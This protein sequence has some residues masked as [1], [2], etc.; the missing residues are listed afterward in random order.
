MNWKHAEEYVEKKR[1][2]KVATGIRC[3]QCWLDK[4]ELC[5]CARLPRIAF[6]RCF[7]F[8]V[9]QDFKEYLNPGDDAKLLL[10]TSPEQTTLI[11]Y[12]FEDQK[13]VD[14]L[15]HRPQ[16]TTS[17]GT[18]TATSSSSGSSSSSSSNVS[19]NGPQRSDVCILFPSDTSLSAAEFFAHCATCGRD[20]PSRL[21]AADAVDGAGGSE[22]GVLTIIVVDA[23][24]RHAR[25]MTKHLSELLP[26]VARV[27]LTPEQFSVY[28]R[29]QTQPDRIC[30]LEATA[31]FLQ[32]C[33]EQE[34]PCQQLI[35]CVKLNNSMLKRKPQS[36]T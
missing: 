34:A 15:A 24:W 29:K 22:G 36:V 12:P 2:A 17:T 4:A 11:L 16:P 3:G 9:Y 30:T 35:D 33:G 28:A 27:Q 25:K 26:D 1:A 8:V 32:H 20:W 10:C 23:V 14:L 21:N 31:L 13:L 19:S 5:I 18:A 7:R 6:N